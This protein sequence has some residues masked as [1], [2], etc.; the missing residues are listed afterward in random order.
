MDSVKK[1]RV[2][3]HLR[4][5]GVKEAG[6]FQQYIHTLIDIAYKD[7]RSTCSLFFLATGEG[8]GSHVVLHDLNAVFVL[9]MDSGNFVESN[10]VPKTHK[11]YGFPAHIVEQI[12]NGCLTAGDKDAVR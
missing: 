5:E 1:C 2:R 6:C 9:E 3:P 12:R 4:R 7:H 10:A 11:S 8:T